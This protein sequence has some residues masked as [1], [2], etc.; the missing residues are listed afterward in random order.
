M[1]NFNK[2]SYLTV[3]YFAILSLSLSLSLTHS[4]SH[5]L[6]LSPSFS[7]ATS[8]DQLEIVTY[9]LT[10]PALNRTLKDCDGYLAVE[11]TSDPTIR[12]MFE[13]TKVEN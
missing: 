5:S 9:L 2:V 13:D 8:C 3:Q 11:V 10:V 6:S 12:K 1:V 4:H 7:L